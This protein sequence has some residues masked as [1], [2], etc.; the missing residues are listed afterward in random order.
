MH[1]H[2][3]RTLKAL[4]EEVA[5]QK[6]TLAAEM[7]MQLRNMGQAIQTSIEGMRPLSHG[8]PE[9][10]PKRSEKPLCEDPDWFLDSGMGRRRS[11]SVK[12]QQSLRVISSQSATSRHPR[13]WISRLD[14]LQRAL[15]KPAKMPSGCRLPE[16]CS[17]SDPRCQYKFLI[18]RKA[19]AGDL[20]AASATGLRSSR[21][22]IFCVKLPDN[23]LLGMLEF[24]A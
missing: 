2:H 11:L 22:P 10:R 15:S 8:V 19:N 7:E 12:V 5:R 20:A 6:P 1:D 16:C 18:A 24:L 3:L 17:S 21:H 23:C 14:L 4:Q 13:E 9:A